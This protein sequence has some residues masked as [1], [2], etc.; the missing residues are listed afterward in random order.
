VKV[1]DTFV[2]EDEPMMVME[3]LATNLDKI[4]MSKKKFAIK[5]I[6]QEILRGV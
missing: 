6:F 5:E 4:V 2:G 1:I 3:W